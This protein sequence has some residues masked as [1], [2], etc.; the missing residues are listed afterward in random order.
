VTFTRYEFWDD[1][2]NSGVTDD[3][4][5]VNG[6]GHFAVNGQIQREGVAINIDASNL[7]QVTYNP[8]S[9]QDLLWV[10]AFDGQ[11]WG[12]WASFRADQAEAAPPPGNTPPVVTGIDQIVDGQSNTILAAD[13]FTA[14]DAQ[15][16]GTI[17][18]YEFWDD[19]A[20]PGTAD[21][22]P[23][24]DTSGFF[25]MNGARL[26]TGESLEVTT[27]QVAD[28]SF[29]SGSGNDVLWVRA[30]DGAAWGAWDR[31][32]VISPENAAPT[33]IAP[34]TAVAPGSTTAVDDFFTTNDAD[35]D[36]ITAYRFW[37][38]SVGAD[39]GYFTVN[40]AAQ[41]TNQNIDVLASNLDDTNFVAGTSATPEE[42]WVQVYDGNKWSAWDQFF[43]T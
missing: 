17:A 36:A 40:G 21:D 28:L 15:G 22:K 20:N 16:N 35:G 24:T 41:G 12:A 4:P 23:L 11:A 7:S 42:L 27:A 10:R 9:A 2:T 14:T 31:F 37:D 3:N 19:N 32:D 26:A 33:V 6:T 29:T 8:G 25:T 34:D 18:K 30:Y 5:A 43:V 39:T 1:N 13:L 38:S